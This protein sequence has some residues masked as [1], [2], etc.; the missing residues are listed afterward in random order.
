MAQ[1]MQ[2][3]LLK[4]RAPSY[5]ASSSD[6]AVG[7]LSSTSGTRLEAPNTHPKNGNRPQHVDESPQKDEPV[8]DDA[9]P[10]RNTRG[11]R[12]DAKRKL[13][14]KAPTQRAVRKSRVTKPSFP[15]SA[16]VDEALSDSEEVKLVENT[17]PE[18]PPPPAARD[19][20][21]EPKRSHSPSL[22]SPSTTG[23]C[24]D[25]GRS[26]LQQQQQQQQRPLER[27][28]PEQHGRAAA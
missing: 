16:Q 24:I 9:P 15:K 7:D 12:S 26:L 22:P 5:D 17:R 8:D 6:A 10:P 19:P 20:I 21:A 3:W 25:D 1:F 11:K 27:R 4:A 18:C 28:L 23:C 13:E 14:T 2:R